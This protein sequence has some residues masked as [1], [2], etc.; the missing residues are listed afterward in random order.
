MT[1][2]GHLKVCPPNLS[3]LRIFNKCQYTRFLF[4]FR[5][6]SG[7]LLVEQ[8]VH[9][10]EPGKYLPSKR[11]WCRTSSLRVVPRHLMYL[12]WG[13]DGNHNIK[14]QY[15]L[16]SF[17]FYF[18][19]CGFSFQGVGRIY[20]CN[21]L[22]L[23]SIFKKERRRNFGRGKMWRRQTGLGKRK[24]WGGRCIHEIKKSRDSRGT[25]GKLCNLIYSSAA[26]QK[27]NKISSVVNSHTF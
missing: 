11:P 1:L 25:K 21:L 20:P 9:I 6:V 10:E 13:S 22:S 19:F 7:G 16:F 14:L 17:Y 27:R 26:N 24:I 2:W 3:I 5:R 12:L 23:N 15:A 18:T 8:S 4:N